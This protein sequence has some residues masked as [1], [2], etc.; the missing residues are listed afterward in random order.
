MWLAD[1]NQMRAL[2]GA[3]ISEW[4]VP[5]Q[6]LMEAAS[7]FVARIAAEVIKPQGRVLVVAGP[8]NNGGDGWGTARHLAARGIAV[9][10][11]TSVDP[12]ELKGDAALQFHIYDRYCLPWEKYNSTDQFRGC[13]LLI[14]AL[15]GTGV[16]GR[17]RGIAEEII[18]GINSNPAPVL[19]VDIPSGLPAEFVPPEGQV[20]QAVATATFGLAKT[21]LYTPSGRQASGQIFID[22]IGLPAGLLKDTGV[23][24][25]DPDN[26]AIGL[27]RRHSDSH[28]GIYGHG[29]LIAGSKG[30]SGAA[31][32]A[33]NSALRTGIG[34]LTIACPEAVQPVLA[35]SIWEALTLPLAATAEGAFAPEAAVQVDLSGYSAAA[36]GPGCRVCAGTKALTGRMLDSPLPLVIDADGLNVLAPGIPCRDYPTILCPHPG[37]MARLLGKTI[38]DVL[39]N[40]LDIS[41]QA[42]RDWGCTVILKGSTTC[43]A[44][45]DGRAALNITGTDGLATG[46][47]GDVLT[48]LVLGLLTMGAEAFSAACAAAWLLGTA[49]ELAGRDLGTAAQ[50]PRD[51]LKYLAQT[52]T[53][54]YSHST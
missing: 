54:L 9:H 42:A 25:N 1:G 49:S 23:M 10:V 13:A 41:R 46:G 14:D 52:V 34:L 11:V 15:L 48:G 26:A 45:P 5:G 4:G 8:G 22:P 43:I 39:A 24:L 19:A 51:V 44:G 40:P 31:I 17:P 29:L 28:K 35:G 21:G 27:P 37:E 38:K 33:G 6:N 2:D 16:Q 30:M 7:G 12:H 50:L 3:A 18:A 47:S 53:M 32:L 20:V 36:I